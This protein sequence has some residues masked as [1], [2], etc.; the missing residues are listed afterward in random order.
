MTEPAH[1]AHWANVLNLRD[2]VRRTDGSVGELQMSLAKAVYQTVP[3]PYAKCGYYTDITQPT[4]LLVGFLGRVARRLW[5]AGVEAKACFHLDQGMGGGKSHALVGIWHMINDTG[6]FLATELGLAVAA[7]ATAGGHELDLSA[8]APIILIGDSMSPGKT[9]PRFGP[10]TDLFGRFLWLLFHSHPDRMSR[11]QHY[12]SLGANKATLQAAFAEIDRPV[13]VVIDELMDYVMMLNDQDAIG[14]LPGEQAFLNAL[15]DA[16]DDQPHVA[17]IV[18][19]IRSDKDQAGYPVAAEEIRE[20]I[21]TRLRRNGETVTVTEPADFAQIIR[22]RL[23]AN[24]IEDAAARRIGTAYVIAADETWSKE[25]YSKLGSARTLTSLPDRTAETYPFHPDL[26]ELIAK[27]WSV[28]QAFQQVRSTVDIFARTVL[29]WAIEHEAGRWAPDLIGPGDIPLH[30]NA[31]EALLSSG[32]L[33]G[34]ARAIQ[35]FR[36]VANTDIVRSGGGGGTAFIMDSA[37]AVNGVSAGQPAPAVRM[38]T[39]CFAYSLVP[40]A[41]AAR[42]ATK[43]E[44]IAAIAGQDVQY[45]TAEEVFNA[46][47]ASPVQGGLGALE[48]ARPATGKGPERFYL[49][50]KQT[51]NMYH[52]NATAMVSN[53]LALDRVWKRAQR[54]ASKGAFS[55]PHFAEGSVGS[56]TSAAGCFSGFDGQENRLVVLDPRRWSLLNGRD[57]DTRV[58]LN[59]AF[60]VTPGLSATYAAS[61]VVAMVNTQRRT[62]A[63]DR[64]RD[65][66]AWETVVAQ[67]D[68]V[69]DE[70]PEACA[71]RDEARTK[72]DTD[73]KWAYQHY[74]YLLRTSDGLTVQYKTMPDGRSALLGQEVWNELVAVG[75]AV[76]AGALAPEYVSQL[77][78]RGAFG[79]DLTPI[80]LFALPYSDPT[81]PLVATVDDLRQAL[82][83][84]ATGAEW[85]LTDSDGNEIRPASPSQ[86]Q[87][88]SMQQLLRPR[89]VLSPQLSSTSLIPVS[90]RGGGSSQGVSK[91]TGGYAGA[92]PVPS[93]QA[94][95]EATTYEVTKVRMP[96]SSLT[97]DAKR[98]A[99]WGLIR[100]L[101]SLVDPARATVDLQMLGLEIT[102]T[103][104]TRDTSS[105]LSKAKLLPGVTFSI[106]EEDL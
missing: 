67:L 23:F 61:M 102:V 95:T 89:P 34:S 51:L 92:N 40:R 58:D 70:Y 105:L 100:E 79:R 56:D 27:E 36:A 90:G 80:E 48:R 104:R 1:G 57:A 78:G 24:D 3:V 103:A 13:L 96:L 19:M 62:R 101:A 106:E 72:L 60:G 47:T 87:P 53:D 45:A 66:L 85:M 86:I 65:L 15:A 22:R 81:W 99:V 9:D 76:A 32:V 21:A 26:F 38:A 30:T 73:V 93:S 98:E 50:I 25:V 59:M 77:I 94:E 52:A 39:A 43:P 64:A 54:L 63:R 35:G 42:G 71:R 4:P 33:A 20:Y 18:V 91:L 8:V 88:A 97:N 12:V 82:F 55:G 28:V 74:A 7:E 49:S 41:Q 14:G 46:L 75:R 68:P 83:H 5:V 69:A 31:L 44:L 84:L 2:E 29:H 10:A 6:L 37:L 16:V 11:W 17:L